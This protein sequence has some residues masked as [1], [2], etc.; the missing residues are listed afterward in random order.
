MK[1]CV[2]MGNGPSLNDM[3]KDILQ[4]TDSFGVNYCPY[5][6][7]YYVC[8]DHDILINHPE[9][10]LKL[11]T[12]AKTA[13]LAAK[14]YGT[15]ELYDLANL[16]LIEKDTSHFK[17]EHFFSGL[18]VVYVALKCAFYLGYER[19]HLW[20]VD[21]S[22]EWDHYKDDYPRGDIEHRAARMQEMEYHYRLAQ[23]VYTVNGRRIVNHSRHS[24][25]DAIFPRK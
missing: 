23:R 1:T 15:S 25:L 8:I 6:P 14:E 16:F 12:E 3:P 24:K 17:N 10:I 18:T 20:G 7:T 9:K 19:I 2:I 4:N 11:A 22:P 5:S 13:F 21:H